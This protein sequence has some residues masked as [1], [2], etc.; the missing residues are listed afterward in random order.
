MRTRTPTKFD[1]LIFYQK[2]VSNF[3][4]ALIQDAH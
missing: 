2:I 1:T 4:E 3:A